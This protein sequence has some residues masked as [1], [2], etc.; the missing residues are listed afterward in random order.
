MQQAPIEV[1]LDEYEQ[2][3]SVSMGRARYNAARAA[4]VKDKK[5]GDQSNEE[6]DTDGFAAELAF[7]KLMN[8]YPD[9][10]IGAR[11][12][13]V[14]ILL[15]S[16]KKVDV[17]QTKYPNG[18][19]LAAPH[20]TGEND[21]YVLM[22][23]SLNEGAKFTYRGYATKAEL[24]NESSTVQLTKDGPLTKYGLEQSKLHPEL[25]V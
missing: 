10:T 15:P 22:T 17:K 1:V 9:L 5:I 2:K 16:G 12:G 24:I 21:Y 8:L 13:G 11:R 25:P 4:N 20:C 6:T 7:A 14:D 23:G 3:L 18:K 19:L